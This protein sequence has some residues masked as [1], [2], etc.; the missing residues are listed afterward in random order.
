MIN[1]VDLRPLYELVSERLGIKPDW[2]CKVYEYKLMSSEVKNNSKTFYV[3][4]TDVWQIVTRYELIDEHGLVMPQGVFHLKIKE[5][6][7]RIDTDSMTGDFTVYWSGTSDFLTE[8][9]TSSNLEYAI[10]RSWLNC[11]DYGEIGY[12]GELKEGFK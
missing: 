10:I 6:T 11:V 12:L 5:H 1:E 2:K 8:R 3:Y 4:E 9:V 7:L